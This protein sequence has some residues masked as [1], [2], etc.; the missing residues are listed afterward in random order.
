MEI[1]VLQ[2]C[3][4]IDL[5]VEV[6]E[7]ALT[8]VSEYDGI[9]NDTLSRVAVHAK[10]LHVCLRDAEERL[11]AFDVE[12]GGGIDGRERIQLELD[13]IADYFEV[14]ELT[15]AQCEFK[16]FVIEPLFDRIGV[17]LVVNECR[18]IED[19]LTNIQ[20][21]TASGFRSCRQM[22]DAIDKHVDVKIPGTI[23]FLYSPEVNISAVDSS[24]VYINLVMFQETGDPEVYLEIANTDH[25]VVLRILNEKIFD[26]QPV[27]PLK[28]DGTKRDIKAD[29]LL[30]VRGVSFNKCFLNRGNLEQEEG[31]EDEHDGH[32]CA[33]K[34]NISDPPERPNFDNL[35]PHFLI[36]C[37][38]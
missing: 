38:L 8:V 21:G 30:K 33:V 26:D 29:D 1:S 20:L 31:G 36:V 15:V 4:E 32:V 23:G 10:K 19:N 37:S 12:L 28:V 17:D 34:H 3:L 7:V 22:I 6:I 5:V 18:V 35:P 25:R 24:S 9:R 13:G 27:I 2:Q 16:V 14:R 11:Q